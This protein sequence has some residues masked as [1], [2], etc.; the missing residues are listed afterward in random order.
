MRLTRRKSL[1]DGI[2]L[3]R[4]ERVLS[5]SGETVAT[6]S[7][8]HFPS[9]ASPG[10]FVRLPW[11]RVQRAGWKDGVL[12]VQEIDGATHGVP[13]VEPGTVPETVRE[14]VTATIVVSSRVR[15]PAGGVRITARR[16]AKGAGEP[17]WAF[18]FDRGLDPAD[19][20]LRAQ[21]EQ[22]LEEIRRQTGL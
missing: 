6:D 3:E 20:G 17:R 2:T 21:A 18:L 15:L 10:I 8:L 22:A 12:A 13:L 5:V 9:E 14:R 1:P 16:P 7:A 19:P 11:E 4:G